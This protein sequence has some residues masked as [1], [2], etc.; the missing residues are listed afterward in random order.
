[1]E[2]KRAEASDT[3]RSEH[4]QLRE[5]LQRAVRAGGDT[6]RAASGVMEVLF[7]HALREE[8]FATPPL[9][10][11]PRLARGEF[12]PE[13]RSILP[14]TDRLRSELPRMLEEHKAIV[15]ALVILLQSAAREQ[16][17]STGCRRARLIESAP[18][19]TTSRMP[20]IVAAARRARPRKSARPVTTSSHGSHSASALTAPP[21]SSR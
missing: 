4:G 12:T 6:G 9:R 19:K 17:E 10:L 7:P 20:R 2:E 8:A 5:E 13:M 15:Q 14:L 1:M 3:S 18:M 16:P 21:G 11:L